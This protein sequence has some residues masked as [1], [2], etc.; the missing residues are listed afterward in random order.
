MTSDDGEARAVAVAPRD[1]RTAVEAILQQGG[2]AG[3]ELLASL[4]GGHP[5]QALL[6]E[7]SS[8]GI[9][10]RENRQALRLLCLAGM[11]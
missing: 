4:A 10:L 1:V 8:L 2:G 3:P 5:S 9:N 11:A 7:A 6:A